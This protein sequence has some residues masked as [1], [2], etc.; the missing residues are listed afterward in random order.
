MGTTQENLGSAFAGE[1]QANRTYLAF[2]DQ[3]EIDGYPNLAKLFR[4][5]AAA[6]TVHAH[7]HLR[8]M[9]GIKSSL[10]N[11]QEAISGETFEFT[12]MYPEYLEIAEK[13]KN[14][15][16]SWSFDVAMQVEKIHANLYQAALEKINAGKDLDIDTYY[17]CGV[18]G[19][20]FEN[21][22]PEKCPICNAKIF[23]K[24]S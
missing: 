14:K 13:E 17:V 16:A 7:N 23:E 6:E 5:A 24:I 19:N 15:P 2:A 1:S 18:C 20:T 9:G 21:D 10:E 4:A 12:K 11:V 3:A 22:H 8:R